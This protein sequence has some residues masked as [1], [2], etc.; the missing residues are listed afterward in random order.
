[1]P[2]NTKLEI[3]TWTFVKFFGVIIGFWLLYAVRDI[4]VL[5]FIVL[6]LVAAFKPG[7]QFLVNNKIP[8][9]LAAVI[10]YFLILLGVSLIIYIVVPPIVE[11]IREL[12]NNLPFLIAKFTPT[13][14]VIAE[15]TAESQNILS[16]LSSQLQKLTSGFLS[17]TLTLFGGIIS[18][19]TVF[20]LSFYLLIEERGVEKFIAL[21]IPLHHKER[22][23][24]IL[25][26]IDEK[27]GNWLR[28]QVVLSLIIGILDF[29]ALTLIGIPYA[30]TL[31]VLGGLLEIVSFVGPLVSLVLAALI[32]LTTGSIL[33]VILAIAI[34]LIIQ[35]IENQL[36]VPKLMSRAVGLSPII[37]ILALLIGAKLGGTLGAVIA[38]PLA[39]VI[40]VVS[41]EYTKK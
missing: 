1:M 28:G 41:A 3:S 37:I 2:N 15:R 29:V 17:A 18:A 35:Q 6:I 38:V 26:K 9:I 34:Y 7:V 22:F 4:L 10:I 11:Q 39:A 12:A 14:Q 40:S 32:A 23:I 8:R 21:S 19:L 36:I 13:Y 25:N 27:I 30:L 33:K 5:L 24:R 20:V 16:T 31:A